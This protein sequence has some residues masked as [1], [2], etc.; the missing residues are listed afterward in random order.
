MQG[1]ILSLTIVHITK[2]RKIKIIFRKKK[3]PTS[4]KLNATNKI[5]L[6]SLY[7]VG[8]KETI[9]ASLRDVFFITPQTIRRVRFI[10]CTSMFGTDFKK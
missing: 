7:E 5:E 10:K 2:K 3:Q 9:Y 6:K 1:I 8:A 4:K